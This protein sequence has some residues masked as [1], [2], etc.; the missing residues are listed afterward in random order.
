MRIGQLAEEPIQIV[1]GGTFTLTT[2]D[3]VGDAE[4][5]SMTFARLPQVVKPGD[6]L[7]LNDGIIELEV[8]SV[9]GP[10]SI[11]ACAQAANS[12]PARDSICRPLIWESR[13][14]PSAT[15]SVSSLPLPMAWTP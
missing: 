13:L 11:V 8:E 7:F 9:A 4:Q 5:A 2:R 3:I 14:S 12:D 1:P 6:K 10:T 15:A